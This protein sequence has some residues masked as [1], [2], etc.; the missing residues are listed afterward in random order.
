MTNHETESGLELIVDN[1]KLIIAFAL[2][3]V[4]CGGFFVVGF[5][6]GKRQGFQEG[7]QTAAESPPKKDAVSTEIQTGEPARADQAA[8]SIRQDSGDQQLDWYKNVNR[9]AGE[10]ESISSTVASNAKPK[11]TVLP[12]AAISTDESEPDAKT[13]PVTYSV[14]VG[15]FLQ[16][17]EV[18]TRANV[19]REKG[20]DCRIEPPQDSGEFYLLKVGKFRSRAEAVAIQLQLKKSGFPSFIKTN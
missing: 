2:L 17:Q 19:L 9:Q 18:E 14:Q 13:G 6:E 12:P 5:M 4:I 16:K 15:A 10:P 1:R 11:A 7:A 8:V 20:F 3:I